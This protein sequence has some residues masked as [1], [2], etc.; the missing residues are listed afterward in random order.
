MGKM[1][2]T[3]RITQIKY[4]CLLLSALFFITVITSGCIEEKDEKIPVRVVAAGSL[5]LPF[6]EIEKRYEE[7]Y[8]NVDL[9]VE[10]HGSIQAI[11]QVTDLNRQ[12]D[13]V[14]VADE[15]LIPLLMYK[16]M[17]DSEKNW[18]D[19]DVSFGKT[20]MVLVYSNQSK[21]ADAISTDNWYEILKRPDVRFG[22]A[23]PVLDAAGYRSIMVLILADHYY[24][25]NDILDKVFSGQFS[26][27]IIVREEDNKTRVILPEILKPSGQKV[28]IRDG[29]IF[30]L[31][32]L[33]TGGV[34]YAFE[35]KCV[36]E[37]ANLPFISLPEEVNLGNNSYS[38][39][40]NHA[41]V[42]LNFERFSSVNLTRIGSPILYA[43]A[44]P[45][46]AAHPTEALAFIQELSGDN[47]KVQG[48]PEP[49]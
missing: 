30:L 10:G 45:K 29:S 31:S 33:K 37:G 21:Y 11:R 38:S 46:N 6:E 12:F 1:D 9:L 2:S 19:M 35:Y 39:L 23:N 22:V 26:P 13:V 40:Y 32:L 4:T 28:T 36:A 27:S 49:L 14:A 42:D 3:D 43:A 16:P 8:P 15:S 25:S 34:D 24:D 18:T 17:P 5:L 47:Q 41:V 48:M 20:E 7:K 44:I